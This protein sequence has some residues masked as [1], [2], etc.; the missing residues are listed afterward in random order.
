MCTKI[1]L[2]E[3]LYAI[4]ENAFVTSEY[5][6]LLSLEDHCSVAQQDRMANM[7]M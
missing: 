6:L 7:F 5:P 2:M 3:V 4:N 1:G